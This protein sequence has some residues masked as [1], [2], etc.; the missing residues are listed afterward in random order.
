MTLLSL[1][2]LTATPDCP[3]VG[4]GSPGLAALSWLAGA[5]RGTTGARSTRR[6]G[7][8]PRAPR[9]SPCTG[10]PRAERPPASSSFA[11]SR[12]GMSSCTARCPRAGRPPTSAGS[13]RARACIVFENPEH[14]FPAAHPLLARRGEPARAHRGDAAG[15]AGV[16]G[17]GVEWSLRLEQVGEQR[18]VF[19]AVASSLLPRRPGVVPFLTRQSSIDMRR[20]HERETL[21]SSSG[22]CSPSARRLGR[23]RRAGAWSWATERRRPRRP[24]GPRPGGGA[25]RG[26]IAGGS[27]ARNLARWSGSAVPRRAHRNSPVRRPPGRVPH[28][29]QPPGR[30]E[31]GAGLRPGQRRRLPGGCL[32]AGACPGVR[33]RRWH[34][35]PLVAAGGER[36]PGLRQRPQGQR[37]RQRGADQRPRRAAVEPGRGGGGPV[38]Q[39]GRGAGPDPAGTSAHRWRR[40]ARSGRGTAADHRLRHRGEGAA[41]D[42]RHPEGKPPGLGPPGRAEQHRDVPAGR[43][44]PD[45]RG[46]LPAVAGATTRAGSPSGTTPARPRAARPSRSTCPGRA[47]SRPR[48]RSSA[49][50]TPTST[51]T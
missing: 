21:G 11:S 6:C 42:V 32:H 36:D 19:N 3:S 9:C 25:D 44:R 38:D 34:P 37:H 14:A 46:A 28:R 48:R 7:W 18:L 41:G 43:R 50:P 29:S 47:G 22:H 31:G 15:K 49:G 5:G 24:G 40:S 13:P 35:P 2:L 45:R 4:P 51:P 16:E 39:R 20:G 26:S 30:G 1:L 10:T 8:R 27:R 17:V 33:L 12:S 23:R